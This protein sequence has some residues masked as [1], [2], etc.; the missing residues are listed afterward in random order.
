MIISMVKG[1][2]AIILVFLIFPSATLADEDKRII[3]GYIEKVDI[4]SINLKLQAKLDT[5]ATTTSIHA[6]I[7][8]TSESE[9]EEDVGSDSADKSQENVVFTIE[10]DKG[11]TR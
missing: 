8:E 7:L 6:N 9:G 4:P 1:L 5:G 10:T 2:T 11:K 3:V